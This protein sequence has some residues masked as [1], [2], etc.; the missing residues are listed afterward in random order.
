MRLGMA[1][2]PSAALNFRL[3]FK[4]TRWY[5]NF[6]I[7]TPNERITSLKNGQQLMQEGTVIISIEGG[8][9]ASS[10]YNMGPM[11][12]EGPW[13]NAMTGPIISI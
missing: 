2:K 7:N 5:W 8:D 6:P 4:R 1:L 11:I 10:G 3:N 9:G 12:S 13:V